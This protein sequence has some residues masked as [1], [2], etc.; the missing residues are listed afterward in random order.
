[1]KDDYKDPRWQKLRLQRMEMDKWA[2]VACLDSTSTL[3]VHHR[4]YSGRI[5]QSPLSDLQTLCESCHEIIGPHPK[6]GVFWL[7]SADN[8]AV[9]VVRHCPACGGDNLVSRQCGEL[10]CGSCEWTMPLEIRTPFLFRSWSCCFGMLCNP[11][12]CVR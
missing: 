12:K 9:F 6:G 10:L 4:E 5:W 3:H 11:T 8:F 1:M 2:C 7:R